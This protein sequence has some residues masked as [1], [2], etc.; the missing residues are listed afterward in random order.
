[1]SCTVASCPG[2]ASTT[3]AHGVAGADAA[4]P[5]S[6]ELRAR[7]RCD[8]QPKPDRRHKTRQDVLGTYLA[9]VHTVRPLT[10]APLSCASDLYVRVGVAPPTGR[11]AAIPRRVLPMPAVAVPLTAQKGGATCPCRR[12]RTSRRS[13]RRCGVPFDRRWPT[14]TARYRSCVCPLCYRLASAAMQPPYSHRRRATST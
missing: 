2:C 1:M 6:C 7:R 10:K 14:R 13:R 3:A 9:T 8:G 11:C 12:S 4:D 5:A